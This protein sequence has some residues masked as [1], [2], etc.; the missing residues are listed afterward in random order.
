ALKTE[1]PTDSELAKGLTVEAAVVDF[2]FI[3]P[4]RNFPEEERQTHLLTMILRV[5]EE[6]EEEDWLRAHETVPR[7]QQFPYYF[8]E[9]PG[10]VVAEDIVVDVLAASAGNL[11]A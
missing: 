6:D 1:V 8:G 7:C 2:A 11:Y 3:A 9:E 10:V 5:D 4:H